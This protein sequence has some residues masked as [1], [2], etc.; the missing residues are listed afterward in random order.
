[1]V[2]FQKEITKTFED[3]LE[4][5]GLIG[6]QNI[7]EVI[8][9][10]YLTL[11][12]E[13]E[14]T[15]DS[16]ILTIL[17]KAFTYEEIELHSRECLGYVWKYRLDNEYVHQLSRKTGLNTEER[18]EEYKAKVAE[19]VDL[20]YQMCDGDVKA[21]DEFELKYRSYV[22]DRTESKNL[23]LKKFIPMG[24]IIS[25]MRAQNKK[26]NFNSELKEATKNLNTIAS[27]HMINDLLY[28]VACS[29][30]LRKRRKDTKELLEDVK[31]IIDESTEEQGGEE[32]KAEETIERL[33]Q[34]RDQYKASLVFIKKSLDELSERIEEVSNDK[35]NEQIR[36]FFVS[37]NSGKY[38]NFLDKIP[39]TEEL[40]KELRVNKVDVPQELK[41][42]LIFIK[43]VIKFVKDHEITPIKE[44]N[45]VFEGTAEDIAQMNYQ[46][47]EFIGDE[48]K[49]LKVVAP[50]YK[51]KEY[52]ISI[53]TV[54]EVSE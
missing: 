17:T 34:E 5:E 40:L 21:Y 9:N 41:K 26:F 48:K 4:R 8:T 52:T 51:Y 31:V 30:Q 6:T 42:V 24:I 54:E 3:R 13:L 36:D 49:K 14:K 32:E 46:G 43:S 15:F 45:T 47:E 12:L 28:E 53:P 27:K 19:L 38:G 44:I 2:K 11:I 25:I 1:M 16:K 7:I 50:G 39:L 37:L 29:L 35:V 22:F 10:R 18:K 20:F 23:G 33:R